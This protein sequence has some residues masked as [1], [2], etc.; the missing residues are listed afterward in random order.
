MSLI[1]EP[2]TIFIRKG[3]IPAF[4][5]KNKNDDPSSRASSM[6]RDINGCLPALKDVLG[7][8]WD[9]KGCLVA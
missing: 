9:I 2:D 7:V 5:L 1:L 4:C 3:S 8:F 6:V